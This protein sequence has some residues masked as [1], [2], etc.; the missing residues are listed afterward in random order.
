MAI[1][2]DYNHQ[3]SQ[4]DIT[5]RQLI[6]QVRAKRLDGLGLDAFFIQYDLSSEEGIAL[7]CLAEAMLHVP[8]KNNMDALIQD[9][10]TDV[11][12]QKGQSESLLVNAASWGLILTGKLYTEG[13]PVIM[14]AMWLNL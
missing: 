1:L 5:A 4:I 13:N 6:D 12:W 3:N 10:L 14:C 9:K 11:A 2:A 7:M 8:D